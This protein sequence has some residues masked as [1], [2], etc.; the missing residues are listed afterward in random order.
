MHDE[1]A[2]RPATP[3]AKSIAANALCS[4]RGVAGN[5]GPSKQTGAPLLERGLG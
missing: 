1:P 3:F 2:L 4:M 5:A